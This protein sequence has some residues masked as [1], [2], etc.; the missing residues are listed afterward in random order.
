MSFGFSVSDITS[1]IQLT[2]R[3]YQGWK[4]ACGEYAEV[5]HD[6]KNLNI[7]LS[8]VADEIK[9]PTSLLL[10]HDHDLSHLQ[11]IKTNCRQLVTQ[12][13]AI[14]TK[15]DGIVISRRNNWDRIRFGQ[16]NLDGIRT[17]L[18]LQISTLGTYLDVIGVSAM[19][20]MDKKLD[21]LPEALKVDMLKV[22]DRLAGEIRAGRREGSIM[23]TYEDDEKEVWRQFRRELISEGF[24]S[25]NLKK[26][27][28]LLRKYVKRMAEAGLLDEEVPEE[29]EG[30]SRGSEDFMVTNHQEEP[31]ATT[32]PGPELPNLYLQ[33]TVETDHSYTESLNRH[34]TV[35]VGG[36]ISHGSDN[37]TSSVP[38]DTVNLGSKISQGSDKQPCD[39]QESRPGSGLEEIRES[40]KKEADSF[41]EESTLPTRS[42]IL[43]RKRR[44]LN[45]ASESSSLLERA[46]DSKPVHATSSCIS[47][48]K[49]ADP[50]S[51][52]ASRRRPLLRNPVVSSSGDDY[53]SDLDSNPAHR[54]MPPM[55]SLPSK[56]R[57][58]HVQDQ[59]KHFEKEN[60]SSDQDSEPVRM[61]RPQRPSPSARCMHSVK[62]RPRQYGGDVSFESDS[63]PRHYIPTS[64]HVSRDK[65]RPTVIRY[66]T[67]DAPNSPVPPPPS[68]RVF[69]R[70]RS[71]DKVKSARPR[72]Q[73]RPVPR[74]PSPPDASQA[75]NS[76]ASGTLG[77]TPGRDNPSASADRL[78]GGISSKPGADTFFYNVGEGI[79][80]FPFSDPNSIFSNYMRSLGDLDDDDLFASILG[81]GGRSDGPPPV[82][83][84]SHSEEGTH[85][86]SGIDT[87]SSNPRERPFGPS[88]QPAAA[89]AS[90]SPLPR[91]HWVNL[92]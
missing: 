13:K 84:P 24:S 47:E 49:D 17:K 9:A 7:I 54:R 57:P 32:H 35:K 62:N 21:K 8:Q 71:G 23:T 1:L 36:E 69:F 80:G 70:P 5:T 61:R 45:G 11:D 42:S 19:G 87:A 30:N 90:T 67:R 88:Q 14:V 64:K 31:P 15:Y 6:L 16:K 55:F 78:P 65:R 12:L 40:F 28:G 43:D 74:I 73:A 3:T 58:T 81:A 85:R 77:S 41:S 60:F 18:G 34:G 48:E 72:Y 27:K 33:P 10:H 26:T 89:T 20:R 86:A 59:S 51:E 4:K 37:T 44:T 66:T 76:S 82:S 22:V 38:H 52:P 63:E 83:A 75:R 56:R 79:G 91:P 29:S 39:S 68:S 92:E 50:D 25:E 2:T 53:A 46:T